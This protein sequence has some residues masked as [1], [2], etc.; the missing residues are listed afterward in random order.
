MVAVELKAHIHLLPL[1]SYATELELQGAMSYATCTQAVNVCKCIANLA[2]HPKGRKK[3][4]PA[5]EYLR[6]L[7]ESAEPLVRKH[8]ASAVERVTWKP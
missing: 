7:T 2:E 4:Q 8:A 1:L 5:L 6:P 3:L